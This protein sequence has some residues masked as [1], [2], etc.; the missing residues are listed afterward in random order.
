MECVLSII[1]PDLVAKLLETDAEVIRLVATTRLQ[2]A[3]VETKSSSKCNKSIGI[4]AS[5]Q[6]EMRAA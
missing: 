6:P 4:C 3:A 2:T 5:V 1:V